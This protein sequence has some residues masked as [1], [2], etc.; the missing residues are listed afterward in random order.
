[1][2][3]T[4]VRAPG[5]AII[6]MEIV[7]L[8]DYGAKPYRL[9]IDFWEDGVIKRTQ[10]IGQSYETRERTVDELRLYEDPE[11]AAK[12]DALDRA[13]A[14]EIAPIMDRLFRDQVE[15]KYGREGLALLG[16]D[17]GRQGG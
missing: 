1:M 15:A 8:G 17:E 14:A 11:V 16:P 3:D 5:L 2:A 7:G 12:F 9:T 4:D 6:G 13:A 10:M